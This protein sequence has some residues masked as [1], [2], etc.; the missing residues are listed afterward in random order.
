[1]F[2]LVLYMKA[3]FGECALPTT[4]GTITLVYLFIQAI[5]INTWHLLRQ[6]LCQVTGGCQLASLNL[7]MQMK[8]APKME[9]KTFRMQQEHQNTRYHANNAI[10]LHT[11]TKTNAIVVLAF[12][13]CCATSQTHVR[14][15]VALGENGNLQKC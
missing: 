11:P 13:G 3:N 2:F 14:W 1:M 15:R 12:V 8:I 10:S 6:R 9:H 5:N 7:C 4:N